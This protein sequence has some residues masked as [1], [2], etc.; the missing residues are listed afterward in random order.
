MAPGA[1]VGRFF[2]SAK[3]ARAAHLHYV[4]TLAQDRVTEHARVRSLPH[5]FALGSFVQFR[6]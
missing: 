4:D 6:L 1:G 5:H 3:D 2:S